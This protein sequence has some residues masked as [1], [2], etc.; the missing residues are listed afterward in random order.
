MSTS[1]SSTRAAGDDATVGTYVKKY[2]FPALLT[3][4]AIVFIVVNSDD[5]RVNLIAVQVTAP[6]WLVYAILVVVGWIIGWF[7]H[8]RSVKRRA[9]R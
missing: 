7:G 2:W 8:Q 3:I 9:R 5:I 4:L 6:A 1:T